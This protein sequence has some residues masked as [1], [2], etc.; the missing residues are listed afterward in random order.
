MPHIP[1]RLLTAQQRSLL[2]SIHER[3]SDFVTTD[4]MKVWFMVGRYSPFL[5]TQL[6]CDLH[7]VP[8]R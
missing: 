8:L 3:E 2:I 5:R 4:Q 1:L 6:Y 7:F